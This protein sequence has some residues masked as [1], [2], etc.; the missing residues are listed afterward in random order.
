MIEAVVTGSSG[1]IGA[2]LVARLRASGAQ[3][4]ALST[5]DG[6][7]AAGT[8]W[9]AIPPARV[10]FHLAGRSYVPDSWRDSAAFMQTNV[11][12]TE[13]A[14]S[15]C[16][17]T[18]AGMV[19]ASAYVYGIPQR[20]PI[21]EHDLPQPNNPYALS[22]L[23]AEE[24]GAFSSAHHQVPVTALRIFNVFGRGQRDAFLIPTIIRQVRS[25]DAICVQDLAPRRDYVHVED[26]V[27]AM[28][29]AAQSLSGFRR[30]NIGSGVSFSVAEIID[31]VQRVA[32]TSLPIVSSNTSRPN[33]IPDVRADISAAS[34]VLGWCPTFSFEDGIRETMLGD[35]WQARQG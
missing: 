22:K 24:L 16:R 5:R 23:M 26:V 28:I 35:S 9:A 15:Y 17:R 32:G 8:T 33:E 7:V 14:L 29:L 4:L 10:V 34:T 1:F 20:L 13:Q 31:T 2:R 11:I 25:A 30:L 3:V 21:S 18:G 6:D 19:M 27:D 12:G